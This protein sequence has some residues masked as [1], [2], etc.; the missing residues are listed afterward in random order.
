MVCNDYQTLYGVSVDSPMGPITLMANDTAIVKTFFGSLPR[1]VPEGDVP[2]L[3]LAKIQM[4][5]YL[6]GKRFIFELPLAPEGTVF[7]QSV[8][9]A[10]L[11]IPYGE[12]KSYGQIAEKIGNPKACR[13]VGMANNRNPI[14]I[15]IPCHRVI[16]A[17]G[18]LVGYAGGLEYKQFLLK[19]ETTYAL[20]R[21][22]K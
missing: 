3:Q 12:T 9:R 16:G 18:D 21:N 14:G 19:L 4:E 11:A 7:Q 5:E 10:L 15:I 17:N 22:N 6:A 20:Y 8:W 2:L 1:D 13:A